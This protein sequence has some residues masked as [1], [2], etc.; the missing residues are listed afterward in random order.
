MKNRTT[1][2]LLTA[3]ICVTANA[4]EKTTEITLSEDVKGIDF[5]VHT[6][7]T[8]SVL[9]QGKKRKSSVYTLVDENLKPVTYTSEEKMKVPKQREDIGFNTVNNATDI[10]SMYFSPS[11]KNVLY[12][13][14]GDY[15]LWNG[16]EVA[17]SK[18]DINGEIEEDPQVKILSLTTPRDFISKEFMTESHFLSI[19]RK[20]GV[21]KYNGGKYADMDIFLYRK[22]LKTLE[23]TYFD[24][25]LPD[26]CCFFTVI[27]PKL[28]YFDEDRFILSY[29]LRESGKTNK[30]LKWHKPKPEEPIKKYRVVTY[31]YEAEIISDTVLEIERPAQSDAFGVT[32]L[33]ETSFYFWNNGVGERAR[34][35]AVPTTES[36]AQLSYSKDEDAFYAHSVLKL[37]EKDDAFMLQK[38]DA[39]GNLLWNTYRELPGFNLKTT[40]MHYMRLL[41]DITK[42]FV[43]ISLYTRSSQ[44]HNKFYVLDKTNGAILAEKEF[45]R[46]DN[47]RV[48]EFLK[49]KTSY[50]SGI[51]LKDEFSETL[52]LD[53]N[54]F[55]ACLYDQDYNKF[56]KALSLSD[57][58]YTLLSYFTPTGIT[59]VAKPENN[60]KLQFYSFKLEKKRT[61]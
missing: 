39:Q 8:F 26:D 6:Y 2:L 34:I 59:T 17:F 60:E 5:R 57:A 22:D 29:A 4:Q 9:Q 46:H 1:I 14:S 12:K 43:G 10:R 45:G 44:D 25:P 53:K 55:L 61:D 36:M 37:E 52:T 28:L 15:F 21:G 54:T 47:K 50:Y 42:D 40:N 27:D 20:E 7:G 3:L 30:K 13:N 16:Q 48:L 33:S 18:G 32:N 51:I 41:V 49:S 23:E 58:N 35:E 31:T 11:G 56:I 38:F 19:G 24:L